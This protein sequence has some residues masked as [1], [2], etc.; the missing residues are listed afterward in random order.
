MHMCAVRWTCATRCRRCEYG[1]AGAHMPHAGYTPNPIQPKP[2]QAAAAGCG[3]P[4]G[5]VFQAAG[6]AERG[7]SNAHTGGRRGGP[8][9]L[10][11]LR[12][13]SAVS[14]CR[15]GRQRRRRPWRRGADAAA[16]RQRAVGGGTVRTK[17]RKNTAPKNP[18]SA[19]L[20]GRQEGGTRQQTKGTGTKRADTH[21][22]N[23]RKKPK[24]NGRSRRQTPNTHYTHSQS[25]QRSAHRQ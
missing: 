20:G 8:A 4:F 2:T 19:E 3:P 7:A 13:P 21:A 23:E 11:R 12:K 5:S 15:P 25:P 17:T 6:A 18:T 22:M 24:N 16:L 10:T 14:R 9:P 1:A